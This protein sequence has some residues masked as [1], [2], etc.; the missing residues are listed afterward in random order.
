MMGVG[1]ISRMATAIAMRLDEFYREYS[2]LDQSSENVVLLVPILLSDLIV[3]C[4]VQRQDLVLVLYRYPQLCLSC[5]M[6]AL[7]ICTDTL[8][9]V[10]NVSFSNHSDPIELYPVDH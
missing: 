5:G 6:V 3:I 8:L 10:Q 1:P 7:F 4:L 9:Y 2:T